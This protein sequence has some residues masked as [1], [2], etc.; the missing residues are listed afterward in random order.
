MTGQASTSRNVWAL[1]SGNCRTTGAS[2]ITEARCLWQHRPELT[3]RREEAGAASRRAS[4]EAGDKVGTETEADEMS[5][6]LAARLRKLGLQIVDRRQQGGMLWA[7]GGGELNDVLSRHGFKF[8]P[9]G[10]RATKNRPGWWYTGK[11]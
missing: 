6:G 9:R 3:R 1:P 5:A 10:G 11:E 8:A 7:V 2:K 4:E